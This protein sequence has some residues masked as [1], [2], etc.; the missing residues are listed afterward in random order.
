MP[1]W[2][3]VKWRTQPNYTELRL[4]L[5]SRME[6]SV[7]MKLFLLILLFVLISAFWLDWHD[8]VRKRNEELNFIIQDIMEEKFRKQREFAELYK[9]KNRWCREV[10]RLKRKVKR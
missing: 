4:F 6:V 5:S 2:G 8:A 3:I 7:A 1:T 9:E 10:D